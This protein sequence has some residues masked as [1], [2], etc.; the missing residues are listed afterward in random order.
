MVIENYM[1][2]NELDYLQHMQWTKHIQL[3]QYNTVD[4]TTP[5]T[6]LFFYEPSLDA[7]VFFRQMPLALRCSSHGFLATHIPVPRH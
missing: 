5:S 7:Q 4:S 3:S 1:S 2:Y 6:R